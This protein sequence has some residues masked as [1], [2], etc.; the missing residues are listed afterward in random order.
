MDMGRLNKAEIDFRRAL[1]IK[2]NLATA[3][4]NLGAVLKDLG[5]L[6]E[7]ELNCRRVLEINPEFAPAHQNLASI[8]GYLSDY[9]DVVIESDAALHLDQDNA[10]VWEKRLYSFSYHPDLSAEQIYAE[11]VRWGDVFRNLS[12]TS[13]GTTERRDGG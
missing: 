4:Y 2:P 12:C 1:E 11:F 13:A 8:L 9:D 10:I 5:R 6:A 7:A 3:L